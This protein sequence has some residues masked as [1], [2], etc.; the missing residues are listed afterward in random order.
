MSPIATTWP[1]SSFEMSSVIAL[2]TSC[3]SAMTGT[4]SRLK[5]MCPPCAKPGDLP[6]FWTSSGTS[7]RRG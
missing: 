3:A 2:G 5:L 4:F 7:N 6:L 1:R